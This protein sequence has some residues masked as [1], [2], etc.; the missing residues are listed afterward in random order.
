MKRLLVLF[1]A[2]LATAV[3]ATGAGANGSPYSP[4][5]VYGWPGVPTGDGVRFVA[6][7]M[8]KST[9]VAAVRTRD[10]H[11]LR[12]AVVKGDYGVPLV[13]YDGTSGGLSGDRGTLA[14]SSYGPR[15]GTRGRT[16]FVVLDTTALKPR[17]TVTLRGSWSYD[18]IAPNGSTLYL[19]QHLRAG[20]NP[21]YRVRTLD[22]ATGRLHGALVDRLE[23]ERDMGGDPVRRASSSD[24]RWAYTLYARR[25]HE[26]FV[27]ALDT[28]RREAFCVD[29]PLDVRYVDQWALRLTLDE[30]SRLLSV[31][32]GRLTLATVRTDSW[33]VEKTS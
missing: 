26:P 9:M 4:G 25:G 2:A 3:L 24:G 5:L 16:T 15:P 12:S 32:R 18:A 6:F 27:H 31:A 1:T 21:L 28:A 11:V 22:V 30:R 17:S 29:L 19:T 20:T 13:A 14:L 7:G 10:G 23:G 33:K 8:P